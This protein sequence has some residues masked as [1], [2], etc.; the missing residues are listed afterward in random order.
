M[1]MFLSVYYI[2]IIFFVHIVY[3]TYINNWWCLIIYII[4]I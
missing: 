2:D 3:F 4:C 1:L